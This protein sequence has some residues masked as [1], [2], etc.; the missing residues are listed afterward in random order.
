LQH[1][2]AKTG[3]LNETHNRRQPFDKSER[4][5]RLENLAGVYVS[6]I[7]FAARENNRM[8]GFA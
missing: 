3:G 1:G 4:K 8:D 7:A 5:V 2:G 6:I